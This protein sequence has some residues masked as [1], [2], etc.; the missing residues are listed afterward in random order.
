MKKPAARPDDRELSPVAC[1]L[2]I[3]ALSYAAFL[4]L[5]FIVTATLV[6]AGSVG[7][8]VLCVALAAAWRGLR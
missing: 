4:L 8:V 2:L 1:V 5:L 7:L 3:L 6:V